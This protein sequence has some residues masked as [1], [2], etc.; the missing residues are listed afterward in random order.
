[1]KH[2]ETLRLVPGAKTAVLFMHGICGTPDHFRVLLPLEDMIPEDWSVCNIRYPGHGGT[3]TDFSRSSMERWQGYAMEWFDRLCESH[4]LVI[5][6]GHSM[7]TLFAIRMA[8][9]RPEK[10]P[11]LFLIEVPLRVGI[12]VWAVRNLL[13]FGFGCLDSRDPAQKALNHVCS[14]TPTK[15]LLRYIGWQPRMAE[16][17]RLMHDTDQLLPQL[18]VPAFAYQSRYDELVSERTTVLLKHAQTVQVRELVSSTHFYYSPK[19]IRRIRKHFSACL[20]KH[21]VE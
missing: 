7:G 13:R 3:V 17:I 11:F 20:R 18:N 16:L 15:N 6:V 9:K 2:K 5:L 14:V 19:E 8:L 10:V 4:E 21:V 12:K 1:M